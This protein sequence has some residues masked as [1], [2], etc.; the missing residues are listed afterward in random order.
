MRNA[1]LFFRLNNFCRKII[2]IF[3]FFLFLNCNQQVEQSTTTSSIQSTATTTTTLG[4]I[5]TIQDFQSD[6][7][8]N[9]R[10]IRV[11]LPKGYDPSDDN[12]RFKVIYMHDGQNIFAPGG[13]YGCWYVEKA[14]ENLQQRGLVEDVIIVGINNNSDRI[15]EY[16]PTADSGYSGSGNGE[17]YTRFI[18]EELVPHINNTFKTKTGPEN[19]A[20]IG[21]SLGGLI[22][23]YIAW[24]HPE[25]FGMAGCV[26]S[27]FW[28][29]N[30]KLLQSIESYNGEKKKIKFWIDAG[31]AEGNDGATDMVDASSDGRFY[32]LEDARRMANKLL[33]LGW[34]EGVDLAYRE[35]VNQ[36]H[37]EG[38]WANRIY[39]ILYFFLK[40]TQPTLLSIK[41]RPFI[42]ELELS[43]TY[44][45]SYASV[46]LSYDCYKITHLTYNKTTLSISDTSIATIDN[47]ND[48]KITPKFAGKT[49]II[50]NY[51][52]FTDNS[53]LFIFNSISPNATIHFNVTCPDA[54][55][56]ENIFMAGDGGPIPSTKIWA[57]NGLASTRKISNT[58]YIFDFTIPKHISFSYKFTRA[59]D[60]GNEEIVGGNRTYTSTNDETVD[61]IITQWKG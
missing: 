8:K 57:P 26:S 10:N 33:K 6:I 9:K 36:G 7:L 32:M 31:T 11:Y 28:W 25:I 47:N 51:G 54:K 55:G 60:W 14:Y 45:T 12:K 3:S 46:D 48:G 22:S 39:D 59:G 15:P 58:N 16:T 4:Q 29:D 41:C 42:N 13:P 30:R 49:S 5:K 61:L 44:I 34:T 18:V 23:M 53:D 38:A 2:F 52:G 40:K 24:N 1:N 21:S 56:V 35:G 19:T 37:N 50:A 20:I 17:L 43:G 27:S